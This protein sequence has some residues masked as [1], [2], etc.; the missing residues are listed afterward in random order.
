MK[1]REGMMGQPKIGHSVVVGSIFLLTLGVL[2]ITAITES[3]ADTEA[4]LE[5]PPPATVEETLSPM[6]M[7]FLERK[8]PPPITDWLKQKLKDTPPFIRD[9]DL[10]LQLRTFYFF[11]EDLDRS[12]K[13]AW[14]IGGWLEYTSGWL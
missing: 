13:E 6:D 4:T 9:T 7:S 14:A 5:F 1:L 3:L 10:N 11:Q 12:H 8:K 2:I